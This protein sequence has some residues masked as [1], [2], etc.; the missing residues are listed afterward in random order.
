MFAKC[1]P[2]WIRPTKNGQHKFNSE[3]KSG[4]IAYRR[5]FQ[6]VQGEWWFWSFEK[7]I[8]CGNYFH[9]ILLLFP[10]LLKLKLFYRFYLFFVSYWKN[11]FQNLTKNIDE[12]IQKLLDEQLRIQH[13][14]SALK[15]NDLREY[16]RRR[17]NEYNWL[18]NVFNSFLK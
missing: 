18:Y 12:F 7:G 2:L 3:R 11:S 9:G 6:R 10:Q 16:I 13:H 8:F 17:L 15:K 4:Q 1:L 14:P 5:C